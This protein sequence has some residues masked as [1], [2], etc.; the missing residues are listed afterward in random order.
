M[1]TLQGQQR[2]A[3]IATSA[4]V[5]SAPA[6]HWRHQPNRQLS[7]TMLTIATASHYPPFRSLVVGTLLR[8]AHFYPVVSLLNI[9]ARYRA[10]RRQ[11][12]NVGPTC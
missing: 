10:S 2:C 7:P 11:S 1:A 6:A 9:S 12:I 5:S 3:V 8:L 4:E